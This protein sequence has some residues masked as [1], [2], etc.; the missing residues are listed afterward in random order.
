MY[1]QILRVFSSLLVSFGIPE[2]GY[3]A[4]TACIGLGI[5]GMRFRGLMM[6]AAATIEEI[7]RTV[8]IDVNFILVGR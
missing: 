6:G 2:P 8:M 4:S 3:R 5:P 1:I 7:D